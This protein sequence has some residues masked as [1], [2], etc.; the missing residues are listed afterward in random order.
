MVI[1]TSPLGRTSWEL[2][3]LQGQ[4]PTIEEETKNDLSIKKAEEKP[5]EENT[6]TDTVAKQG[7]PL[8]ASQVRT[9][10]SVLL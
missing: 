7:V 2:R 10:F 5:S 1:I 9:S 8:T 4:Q 3:P 6:P